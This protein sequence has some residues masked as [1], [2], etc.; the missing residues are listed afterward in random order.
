MRS[1]KKILWISV[2]TVF[3]INGYSQNTGINTA[4]PR[5]RL[6]VAGTSWFQGDNT[7]LPS[8][9]GAGIGIGFPAG[10]TGGYI[11]AWDYTSFTSR[12]LWLQN[13]G[14]SVLIGS[15][16]SPAG[17]LDVRTTGQRG[18]YVSA[19]GSEAIYGTT[20]AGNAITGV[21]SSNVGL[22]GVS[23]AAVSAGVLGENNYIGVQGNN[24]GHDVN[25]QGVRGENSIAA[26]GYAGLFVGGTTWVAGTLQKN[27]G[28]FLID[29]PLEPETKFLY[30]SFV[31]SPDMKNIYDGVVTTN[32]MGLA[33]VTMPDWFGALN[34]DL[35]Y[36]LTCIG[37]FAQAIVIQEMTGNQ[38]VIK[39]DLPNVKVSWL[40]TGIR[41][42]PYARE[43]RIPLE[44]LKGLDEMGKYIYPQGYGRDQ[45][46]LLDVLKPTNFA[47]HIQH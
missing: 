13:S 12:N 39:T 19:S 18:A 26:G 15:I 29:H 40:V 21:S 3:S 2:A 42:D 1:L 38:F 24:K 35:R 27:A 17:K 37:Q 32:T 41:D 25:R 4:T 34:K 31:E 11:F 30:H 23:N 6:H 36:Q 28:A 22:Y 8:Q 46:Y 5:S 10:G 7:P 45:Q 14:G 47:S 9:A 44:K 43:N 33:T 16:G 20:S